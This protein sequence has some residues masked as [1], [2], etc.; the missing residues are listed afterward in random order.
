MKL[1]SEIDLRQRARRKW[2][3][4]LVVLALAGGWWLRK[5]RA[6]NERAA[7]RLPTADTGATSNPVARSGSASALGLADSLESLRLE[8]PSLGL[9]V[10]QDGEL[11]GSGT[12]TAVPLATAGGA[13]VVPIAPEPVLD[14]GVAPKAPPSVAPVVP[15][16]PRR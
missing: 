1:N 2:Y 10:V 5:E 9:A 15:N 4:L 6:E 8:T 3:F 16:L 11:D 14:A 12:A 7:M 13:E